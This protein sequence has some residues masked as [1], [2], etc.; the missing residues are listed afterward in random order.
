MVLMT[1][2]SAASQAN[3]GRQKY[4]PAALFHTFNFPF[5]LSSLLPSSSRDAFGAAEL[6]RR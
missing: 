6:K 4:F 3:E 2:E 1:T 5:K